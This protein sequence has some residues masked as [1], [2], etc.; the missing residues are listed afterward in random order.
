M[1]QTRSLRSVLTMLFALIASVLLA[2]S[3]VSCGEN[4]S[5]KESSEAQ[6]TAAA[7]GAFPVTVKHKFGETTIDSM[8]K[9]VVSLGYSDQDAIIAFG[10]TPVLV[11]EWDGMY[12]DDQGVCD[13]AKEKMEGD[14][15]EIYKG[16]DIDPEAIAT[17]KPDLIVAVYSG[18]SKDDYE[19]LS[20]VAPVVAQTADYGDY[21]QPWD[22]TTKQI[23]T[24]LGQADKAD[25]M[26]KDIKDRSAALAKKHPE[27]QGK[28]IVVGGYDGE[29]L[30]VYTQDDPR[31]RFFRDL[32]FKYNQKVQDLAGDK[33]Y[34]KL[35]LEK[36]DVVD[37]DVIIW[38]QISYNKDGIDTIRKESALA[39][40]PA[41][42]EE[43]SVYLTGELERSF[44]WQTVLSLDYLLDH[45]E[46]PLAKAASK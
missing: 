10:V 12:P 45:I 15:I 7:E 43:R 29:D 42:K 41:Q 19:A 18:I 30:W 2:M 28:S 27:W 14:K 38:D 31:A 17:Y 5:S 32:G 23:G 39:A 24:A 6:S 40:L 34:L 16:E 9:R 37:S 35:S 13:W 25:E 3:L 26:I 22:V 44:G 20:K 36:A 21:E 8:P 33:F 1:N 4:S 46:E 11:R